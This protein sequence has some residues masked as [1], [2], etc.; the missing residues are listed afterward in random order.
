MIGAWAGAKLIGAASLAAVAVYVTDTPARAPTMLKTQVAHAPRPAAQAV[1]IPAAT[2]SRPAADDPLVIK[3]VL[4]LDGPFK[5]G[6][7]YWD[8]DGAPASGPIVITVDVAAQ[9]LSVF[10]AGYEIG[11]A[12]ILFGADNKPTPLGVFKIT[13]KDADHV[14]NLYDAPMPYMLRLTNDGVAIHGSSVER[15]SATNGCVGVPTKFARLLFG[16]AR[17]GDRVI[18]T[19]GETLDVGGRITAI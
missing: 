8:E 1:V 7:Y 12:V 9:T 2:P 11:T 13:Q 18:I 17:L 6:D 14:S 19:K 15:D 3:R 4:T 10:R 5:H 16:V